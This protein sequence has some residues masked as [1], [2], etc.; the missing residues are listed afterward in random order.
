MLE[1]RKRNLLTKTKAV[2]YVDLKPLRY[3]CV[4]YA[5]DPG[6]WELGEIRLVQCKQAVAMGAELPVE[7]PNL[8]RLSGL[9]SR[10]GRNHAFERLNK[11]R[12]VFGEIGRAS[13]RER[14]WVS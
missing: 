2:R 1:A 7:P 9:E 6:H 14:V 13:C 12:D 10:P 11:V 8:N 4:C 3:Q 5:V